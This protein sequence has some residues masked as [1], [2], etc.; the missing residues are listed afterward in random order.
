M[1]TLLATAPNVT[2][3]FGPMLL[4]VILNSV[5]Y[6]IMLVQSLIYYRRYKK[7]RPWFRYLV[8]YLV[9]VETANWLCDIGII[10][11]PLITR[12]ATTEALLVSP[13]FLRT[14]AVLTVF[15][16]TPIQIFI[17]WRVHIITHSFALPSIIIL[18]AIVSLGGGI[19][20]TTIVSMHPEYATFAGFQ[21]EVITWLVSSA[22]CDVFLTAALVHSLSTRKTKD[23]STD[24]RLDKIIRL[25]IQTGSIT[26]AAALLDVLLFMVAP[27]T[28]LNFV[29]DFCLSKLYTN[30]LI[31]TLNAR[32][33]REETSHHGHAPNVLF[34]RTPVSANSSFNLVPRRSPYSSESSVGD[35]SDKLKSPVQLS[36]LVLDIRR[37][38]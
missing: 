31:N 2:L 4:G 14:D 26:A 33:W 7:D 27:H 9:V 19:A 30:S 24:S 12:Y 23:V 36:S 38:S 21:P 8:L 18:L 6:G 22:A 25:A 3:L 28:S 13:V 11:E 29:M 1:S 35:I 5:L 37:T 16:S 15:V 20:T 32:S 10:Y 34:E 17:A